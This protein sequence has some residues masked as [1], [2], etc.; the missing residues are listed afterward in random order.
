MIDKIIISIFFLICGIFN[1]Q[2]KLNNK[3]LD[4]III[5]NSCQCF[6]FYLD[7][8]KSYIN[9]YELIKGEGFV[10]TKLKVSLSDE[11]NFNKIMDSSVEYDY[12]VVYNYKFTINGFVFYENSFRYGTSQ[13]D[14]SLTKVKI[15]DANSICLKLKKG[16]FIPPQDAER[17][18]KQ[19]GL[20]N[21]NFQSIDDH[22][23]G[24]K[25]GFIKS[26]EKD[27]WI[28][29]EEK[30]EKVRTF[31]INARNGKVLSDYQQ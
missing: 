1:S 20:E 29:K 30:K 9:F 21:I 15:D 10:P 5:K 28:F 13:Y 22:Y 18:A 25:Q 26:I 12:L 8:E 14:N 4:S 31:V 24:L 11:S 16:K 17:I 19:N 6:D 23:F 27:V 3:S 7:K 2:I